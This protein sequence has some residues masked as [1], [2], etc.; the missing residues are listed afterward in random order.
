MDKDTQ[1]T[2]AI[3]ATG[4]AASELVADERT[5]IPPVV[6]PAG[7]G[8][9]QSGFIAG[10]T[11]EERMALKREKWKN[12]KRNQRLAKLSAG[13]GTAE[14]LPPVIPS[15]IPSAGSLPPRPDSGSPVPDVAGDKKSVEDVLLVE[16]TPEEIKEITDE[17][18]DELEKS[19]I[20][21]AS[22]ALSHANLSAALIKEIEQDHEMPLFCKKIF[23]KCIP[24]LVAKALNASGIS[25]EHS[26]ASLVA[27]AVVFYLYKNLSNRKRLAKIIAEAGM[28]P[29][30]Q[31]EPEKK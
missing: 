26:D 5:E 25:A 14:K 19:D 13:S 7:N 24:K 4:T 29:E 15:V 10:Q 6:A 20:G 30:P 2:L 16:W 11:E 8:V 27:L 17:L 21:R 9:A 22:K 3:V 12:Q 23:K 18:I 28:K 31:P 1:D